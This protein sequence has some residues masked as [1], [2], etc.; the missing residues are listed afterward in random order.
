MAKR[1]QQLVGAWD[2]NQR[3][4]RPPCVSAYPSSRVAMSMRGHH[5]PELFLGPVGKRICFGIPGGTME[6]DTYFREHRFGRITGRRGRALGTEGQHGFRV[7]RLR[8][9]P[10][11]EGRAPAVPILPAHPWGCQDEG[12]VDQ[13]PEI[14]ALKGFDDGA[15]PVKQRSSNSSGEQGHFLFVEVPQGVPVRLPWKLPMAM[16]IS[17]SGCPSAGRRWCPR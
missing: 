14:A 11:L 6:G 2:G 16:S 4:C 9:G 13:L 5:L 17:R 8:R 12:A 1:S 3:G 7:V 10:G 15:L